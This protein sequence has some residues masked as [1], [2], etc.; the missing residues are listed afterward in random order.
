MTRFS[1]LLSTLLAVPLAL[2]PAAAVA[3]E[4]AAPARAAGVQQ[5]RAEVL[6]VY[7]HQTDAF[8]QG[9]L[10]HEGKFYEST[11]RYGQSVLRRVD[12]ETGEVEMEVELDRQYFGEGLAL[13]DDRL[14][15]LTWHEGK[16]FVYDRETFSLLREFSYDGQGW[17]LTYDGNRLIMTDGSHNLQF[18]DPQT[19]ALRNVVPV[20]MQGRPVQRLNELEYAEGFVYANVFMQDHLVKIDP[21]SGTVMAVIEAGHL[22]PPEE[23]EGMDVLN[24][25]TWDPETGDFFLTGKL[26]PKMFRVQFVPVEEGPEEE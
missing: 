17:G 26:W 4:S 2:A 25:V 14:I 19:F 18:R 23:R 22:I 10:F 9:L 21:R 20:Y 13:V 16:A 15:Q 24:G 8:T 12:V 5:L 11:G 7:P 1:V 3:G 6:G